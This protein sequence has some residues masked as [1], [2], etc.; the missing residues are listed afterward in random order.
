MAV[1]DGRARTRGSGIEPPQMSRRD[2][3]SAPMKETLDASGEVTARRY[4]GELTEVLRQDIRAVILEA[5][6]R[7]HTR[8]GRGWEA[9]TVGGLLIGLAVWGAMALSGRQD[10]RIA[11]ASVAF[12]SA[13]GIRGSRV[14]AEELLPVREAWSQ[15]AR[16]ADA[17]RQEQAA[18]DA[19]P[20]KAGTRSGPRSGGAATRAS[21]PTPSTPRCSSCGQDRSEEW[22]TVFDAALDGPL[23]VQA[24][25]PPVKALVNVG[26][27]IAV[28]LME[29]V[30]TGGAGAPVR[31]RVEKDIPDGP[32]V[33]V[34]RGAVFVGRAYATDTDDRVQVL[35]GWLV[36]AGKT[37]SVRAVLLG[38]DNGLG[39][40]GRVIQ[41]ASRG[42]SFGGKVLGTV[43]RVLSF[44]L[45]TTGG[46]ALG[47]LAARDAAET[48]G[49]NLRSTAQ[50]WVV[51]DKVIQLTAGTGAVAYLEGDLELE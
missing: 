20:Q 17:A 45:L 14:G 44:G 37:H 23:V 5:S 9:A 19:G 33:A 38:P 42:R 13:N 24:L 25:E 36:S 2:G 30:L 39:L 22:E 18:Q 29:Q 27:R 6:A 12:S 11:R 41:R 35:L 10:P 16:I 3:T 1:D 46:P 26:T 31:A 8:P 49:D 32:R 28:T 48:V 47:S 43:G 21:G 4:S 7:E 50:R 34:Q 15:P 40:R 51:S